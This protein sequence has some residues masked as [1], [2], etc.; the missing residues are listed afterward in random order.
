[1]SK[2]TLLPWQGTES[3]EMEKQI[4][5]EV[6]ALAKD[7]D[8]LSMCDAQLEFKFDFKIEAFVFVA[9][10]MLKYDS[11][12]AETREILVPYQVSE[13]EFW[14]NYFYAIECIKKN[15]GLPTRLGGAIQDSERRKLV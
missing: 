15:L 7:R 5:K 3:P 4:K 11:N 8:T 14:R 12:L 10:M 13:D 2:L 9:C 6:Y 1:M